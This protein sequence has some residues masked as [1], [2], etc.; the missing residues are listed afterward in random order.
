[1]TNLLDFG[2]VGTQIFGVPGLPTTVVID[3]DGQLA[4]YVVGATNKATV[5]AMVEAA[6]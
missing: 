4:S 5:K 1:M 6:K 2:T 3:A